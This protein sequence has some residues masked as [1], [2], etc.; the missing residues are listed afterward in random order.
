MGGYTAVFS[1]IYDGT[2][3]G[4]W[5]AAAVFASL[6]PLADKN[7]EVDM[8]LQAIA[9]RTGWP[10]EL[11]EEGIRQLTEPD[12]GSRS[13]SEDGRRL[14]LLDPSRGWGWRFVN[15]AAYREKARK[16]AQQIEFTASGRDA[17][18]KRIA[19]ERHHKE[20]GDVQ[21]RPAESGSVR[22]SDSDADP[23]GGRGRSPDRKRKATSRIAPDDFV[24]D[25]AYAAELAPDMDAATEAEKFKLWEFKTPHHDWNRAWKRWVREGID[26][27]KYARKSQPKP[28]QR[29]WTGV[30]QDGLPPVFR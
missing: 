14:V 13:D 16:Q 8:S 21:P 24:P 6:L 29:D 23:L 26:R 9:G 10:L 4:R 22:P 12:P 27:G 25:L 3:Y 19:R 1:S 5:P 15:H 17:E 11:L 7:G 18:R 20:S 28:P 2:L 30:T